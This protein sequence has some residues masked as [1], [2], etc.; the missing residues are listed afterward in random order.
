M[1][2]VD[3]RRGER[4]WLRLAGLS[5]LRSDSSPDV[6]RM[7][8]AAVHD[9]ILVWGAKARGWWKRRVIVDHDLGATAP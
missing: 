1:S 2:D 4:D 7:P 9:F 6:G 8:Q 5:P 3:I